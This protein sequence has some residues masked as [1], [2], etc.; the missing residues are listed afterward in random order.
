MRR[1]SQPVPKHQ[2]AKLRSNRSHIGEENRSLE[3]VPGRPPRTRLPHR[4]LLALADRLVVI[5]L[6]LLPVANDAEVAHHVR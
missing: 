3:P 5:R 4:R 1:E 2:E 6:E